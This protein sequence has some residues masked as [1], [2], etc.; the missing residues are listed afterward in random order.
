[1]KKLIFSVLTVLTA[2]LILAGCE[3]APAPSSESSSEP[4]S[5]AA[6]APAIPPEEFLLSDE[7]QRQLDFLAPFV[8]SLDAVDFNGVIDAEALW[9]FVF[10]NTDDIRSLY[11]LRQADG[12][13]YICLPRTEG[14]R[15]LNKYFGVTDVSTDVPFY[16]AETDCFVFDDAFDTFPWEIVS[17]ELVDSSQ[18]SATYD[19]VYTYPICDEDEAPRFM[20]SRLTLNIVPDSDGGYHFQAE[21]CIASDI[22]YPSAEEAA[23]ASPYE[24]KPKQVVFDGRSY[25]CTGRN[26]YT[27]DETG[28]SYNFY[29]V[30]SSADEKSREPNAAVIR[31][32]V[33]DYRKPNRYAA[34]IRQNGEIKECFEIK[35]IEI[36]E[37]HESDEVAPPKINFDES[38]KILTA[39]SS[40]RP[41]YNVAV[42]FEKQTADAWFDNIKDEYLDSMHTDSPNGRYSLYEGAYYGGGDIIYSSVFVKD[43]STG[44]FKYFRECGGMYGG[45][46]YFGFLKNGELYYMDS[47]TLK[48][49]NP[50]TLAV[51]FDL[52]ENFPLGYD[53]SGE[54]LRLLYTFRRDPQSMDFIVIYSES[55]VDAMDWGMDDEGANF[56]YRVGILDR[57]GSLLESYDTGKPVRSTFFG[58]DSVDLSLKGNIL[59]MYFH[60]GKGSTDSSGTFNL[61]T[62]EYKDG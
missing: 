26:T 61:E 33:N 47:S 9:D 15:L 17:T 56:S 16:D 29:D 42:N 55:A 57:D 46:Y 8:C 50:A 1:M 14:E 51:N 48:I 4:A 52:S 20:T 24:K 10:Y 36:R 7:A 23:Q 25:T 18:S 3:K 59:H 41:T 22:E 54:N 62:H 27:D 38:T 34:V 58:I 13:S 31:I 6:P 2:V 40:E 49:Y 5:S 53:E 21:S 35:D 11:T 43:N 60:G 44:E 39:K 45:F 30:F 37:F 28:D 32:I 19:L 12:S